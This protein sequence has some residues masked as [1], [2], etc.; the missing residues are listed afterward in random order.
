MDGRYLNLFLRRML[1]KYETASDAARMVRDMEWIWTLDFMSG[2]HHLL[3]R[4]EEW[5]YVGLQLD[6]KLYVHAA[7]PFS[8]SQAPARFSTITQLGYSVLRQVGGSLTGMVDDSLGAAKCLNHG[9]RDMATQ[10]V[11]LGILGW[12]LS[13][14]KCMKRPE[15]WRSTL[16]SGS[17]WKPSKF[18]CQNLKLTDY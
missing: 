14:K 12:T 2:Y 11:V 7:L 5:T 3:L 8:V 1:Y 18:P 15:R 16:A 6:G 17:T 9:A 10:V 13:A 4:P